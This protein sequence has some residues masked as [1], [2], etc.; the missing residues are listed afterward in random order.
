M[1]IGLWRLSSLVFV[2][3]LAGMTAIPTSIDEAAELDGLRGWSRFR[4]VTWPLLKPTSVFV[5]VVSVVLTL[6]TF[7]TVAVVTRGEPGGQ[8]ETLV[9]RIYDLGFGTSFR[10]GYANMLT[11]LMLIVI[12]LVG[13]AGSLAGRRARQA[14]E[15]T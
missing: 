13:I 10:V 8:S 11:S 4:H 3:Y 5:A 7:E 14:R 1:L 2:L 12:V 6:Q 15:A 9:Y